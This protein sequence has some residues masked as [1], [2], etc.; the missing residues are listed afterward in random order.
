[1]FWLSGGEFSVLASRV[2]SLCVKI[3]FLTLD[4]VSADMFP[5]GLKQVWNMRASRNCD[6]Q[7]NHVFSGAE[8]GIICA[9]RAGCG[10]GASLPRAGGGGDFV[11]YVVIFVWGIV[12][13]VL[14]CIISVNHPK[15]P[16]DTDKPR[17]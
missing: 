6:N 13:T 15:T 5:E 10:G 14:G 4:L 1:M 17:I 2:W 12:K 9:P 7:K 11:I 16:L 8:R 3:K